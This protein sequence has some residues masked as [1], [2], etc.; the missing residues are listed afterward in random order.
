MAQLKVIVQSLA[1][2]H[3]E[4]R[5]FLMAVNRIVSANLDARS[6]ITMTYGVV[7]IERGEMT[8]ARAGHCPLIHV[9]ADQ[10]P[11]LRKARFLA[12][13]WSRRRAADRR[14]DDVRQHA[15]GADDP[16]APGDL[17][18]WFTDGIAETM[19]ERFEC[20]GEPAL[21]K[22]V[23]QYAHL[24]FDQLRSYILA[25]L[26]TF[27]GGADQHDDMTMILMKVEAAA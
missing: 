27:A 25:E 23:E 19:N 2:L 7:D 1:R 22:V 8:F 24:P 3:H 9:P 11:G 14:R 16:L 4:P 21:A 6:F 15:A 13:G 10:P 5:E 17:V 18:V 26:R 12:P 20:F